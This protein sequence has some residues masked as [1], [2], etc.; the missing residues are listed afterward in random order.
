MEVVHANKEDLP[1]IVEIY[2]QAIKAGQ[3][4][5]DTEPLSLDERIEWF[6]SHSSEKYPLLVAKEGEVVLGY[7]T[8]SAYRFGRKALSKTAEISYYIHFDHHR[9]GVASQLIEASFN[10]CPSLQVK[11][12]VA[13]LIGCNQGSIGILNKYGFKEWGCFPNIVEI[14]NDTFDHMYYGLHLDQ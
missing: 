5:A 11:T 4:T 9:K 14:G 2:N 8:L 3:R 6:E 13:I 7:L 1:Q 12:L 10:M